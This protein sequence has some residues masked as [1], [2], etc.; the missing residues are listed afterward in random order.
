MKR[1]SSG[2]FLINFSKFSPKERFSRVQAVECSIHNHTPQNTRSAA[3]SGSIRA[4][5]LF[6]TSTP[7]VPVY[8]FVSYSKYGISHTLTHTYSNPP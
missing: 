8:M 1:I 5:S 7:P 2:N 4:G 3:I 6:M